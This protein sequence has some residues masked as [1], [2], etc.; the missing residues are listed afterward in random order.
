MDLKDKVV[1]ITGASEGIGKAIAHAL[2]QQGARLALAARTQA[3][4]ALVAGELQVLGAS[5]LAVPTDMTNSGQVEELVA[6]TVAEFGRVDILI[7]NVGRGLRKPFVDTSDE[8][9][10]RLV[11]ENLSV[12]IYGCR[13]ALPQM[14]K[15]G[16]GLIINIASRSGRVGEANLAAYSA[17]KHGVIGLTKALA[18]EE[19]S[20]GIRVNAI[21]PGPVRTERMEK[22]LP[23][24]D[25]SGWLSPEDVAAAVVFLATS[26]G[27]T[28]QG[29]S[30]DMF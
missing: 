4:L 2:A 3:K 9:W 15:Q 28:M 25:K 8:D 6:K 14:E 16:A 26:P 10:H 11:L 18:E 12:T 5:F 27:R 19:G 17:V 1:I 24:V 13:A 29:Q 30:L 20:K 21:C 7:N 22:I 23:H